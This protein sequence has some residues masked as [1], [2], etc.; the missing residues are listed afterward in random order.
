MKKKTSPRQ[1]EAR[2]ATKIDDEDTFSDSLGTRMSSRREY[3]YV[4]PRAQRL[5]EQ[6]ERFGVVIQ[7]ITSI[8]RTT[9]AIEIKLRWLVAW[10]AILLLGCPANTTK[11]F[12]SAADAVAI[13]VKAFDQ[14]YPARL[15]YLSVSVVDDPEY[16]QWNVWFKP[17][18]K[19]ADPGGH[20][21]IH[22]KKTTGNWTIEPSF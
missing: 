2:G 6:I 7:M 19:F 20:T 15:T 1:R 16:Q 18:G 12:C 5:A 4:R 13:A 17:G 3:D 11:R 8:A 22:V 21:L 14:A 10:L 9:V